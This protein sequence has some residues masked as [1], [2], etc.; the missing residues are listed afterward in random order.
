[1]EVKIG[2]IKIVES[3]EEHAD[4]LHSRLRKMDKREIWL[5][6]ASPSDVLHCP[7]Q[8]NHKT[9]TALYNN[10]PMCMFGTVAI[11]DTNDAIVWALGSD[12]IDENKKSFYKASLQVVNMLQADFTKIWNVVPCDHLQTIDWLKKLQFNISNE[13]FSLKNI[14]MLYFSRC[15]NQKS[16]A[17]VH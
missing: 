14:P 4:F 7:L 2:Q 1:M 16:M 13:Y 6:D 15:N 3:I 12:L 11:D 17:T 9:L 5:H 10:E 8:H